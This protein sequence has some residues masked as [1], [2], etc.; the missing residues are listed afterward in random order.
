MNLN[1]LL[2][3]GLLCAAPAGC[4]RQELSGPPELRPGRDECAECGMI[5]NEERCS[6]AL[7]VSRDGVK[8]HALFDD[9]GCLLD[10][11][12]ERPDEVLEV[13]V[14]DHTTRAWLEAERAT[15]ILA[16]E[17][18]LKTPMGSG[19]AAFADPDA[20]E[21]AAREFSGRTLRHTDLAQARKD[22]MRERFGSPD[23]PPAG[24]TR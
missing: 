4:I 19:I 15:F 3:L 20:A 2:T 6:A 9:I 23:R 14:H 21:L 5:I 18:K 12:Q 13:F 7:L 16:D 22:W 8:E 1:R 10:Y 24:G 11:A 17:T